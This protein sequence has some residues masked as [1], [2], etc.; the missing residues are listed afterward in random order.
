[1][2]V[3]VAASPCALA[4]ATPSAVLSSLA[5]AARQGVLIKGGV[6]LENLGELDAIT[7]D[8]TGTLTKGESEVTDLLVIE[9]QDER[10]LLET[11]AS[12][13][14]RSTHSLARAILK[15]A[16]EKGLDLHP[17]DEVQDSRR[18][19]PFLCSG[20][21]ECPHREPEAL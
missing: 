14:N 13:E 8:K 11:A 17:I 20:R 6:H 4:I 3:L 1:M 7:F 2:T 16:E 5:Q 10:E 19:C 12:L 21:R 18:A 9:A 15:S